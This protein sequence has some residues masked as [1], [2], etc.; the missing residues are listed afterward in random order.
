MYIWLYVY[1]DLAVLNSIICRR[2]FTRK[3]QFLELIHEVFF[4]FLYTKFGFNLNT[5]KGSD[6]LPKYSAD[7]F[8]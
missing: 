8:N 4:K 1:F 7:M 2:V 5:E 3:H 6:I